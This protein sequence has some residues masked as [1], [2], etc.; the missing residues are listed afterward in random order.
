MIVSPYFP[1]IHSFELTRFIIFIKFTCKL[2]IHFLFQTNPGRVNSLATK[3]KNEDV[4]VPDSVM[5]GAR[6][7]GRC[8]RAGARG[9]PRA[10]TAARPGAQPGWPPGDHRDHRAGCQRAGGLLGTTERWRYMNT[11]LRWSYVMEK[12]LLWWCDCFSPFQSI[13][14]PEESRWPIPTGKRFLNIVQLI[15][16][17]KQN[18]VMTVCVGKT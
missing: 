1:A 10:C 15:V 6:E 7:R 2:T 13:D 8:A 5:C 3:N 11:R 17:V 18:K 14:N 9:Q 4:T 16:K 12:I